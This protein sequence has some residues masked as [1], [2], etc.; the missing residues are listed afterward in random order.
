MNA[1]IRKPKEYSFTNGSLL[2]SMLYFSLPLMLGICLQNLYGAVDLWVVSK[3]ATRADVSAVTIGSQLMNMVTQLIIGFAT[4]VTVLIGQAFGAKDQKTLSRAT[5]SGIVLFGIGSIV[6]TLVYVFL[7]GQMTLWMQTPTQAI[8]P[9]KQYLLFCAMGI[10]FIVGYNLVTSILTGLGDAKTPFLFVAVACGINIV[11]D[12]TL[13]RYF[14]L[15]AMGAA[16]A[17]TGAQI[18]SFLFALCFLYKRGLGFPFSK[19]DIHADKTQAK[20]IVRIGAPVAIQN[21]LVSASFLFV[22][23]VIN[24]FGL[25]A[26]AAVGITEK[27]IIFL[28]VIPSAFGTTVGTAS[29]QNFGAGEEGRAWKSLWTGICI[30]LVPCVAILIFC[31]FGG[32]AIAGLLSDDKEVIALAA[33]YLRSYTADIVVVSFVFPLNGYFNSWGKSWFSM[34]HSVISTF[35]VRVPLCYLLSHWFPKDLFMIGWAAP[36]STLFSLVLCAGFLY[37]ESRRTRY[38]QILSS[39]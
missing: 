39:M 36:L 4:G 19:K 16:I 21:V 37:F 2:R 6:V 23:A 14:H 25:A 33:E 28:F 30:A 38:G 13:V 22:T 17:T 27:I 31:Q 20:R 3:F 7:H 9:T 11:L 29:A 10:P 5:G 26:S 35:A 8:V 1:A 34:L 15:G 18:G 12:I 24:Q 32:Q